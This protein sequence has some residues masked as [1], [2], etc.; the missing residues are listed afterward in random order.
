MVMQVLNLW[1]T[2]LVAG[3]IEIRGS[4]IA[5]RLQP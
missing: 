2:L 5:T 4:T 3:S 1:S